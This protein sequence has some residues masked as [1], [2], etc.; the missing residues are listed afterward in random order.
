MLAIQATVHV[1]IYCKG[2]DNIWFLNMQL[3]CD[4]MTQEKMLTYKSN[5]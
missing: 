4:Y 3:K 5:Q 1:L 2:L